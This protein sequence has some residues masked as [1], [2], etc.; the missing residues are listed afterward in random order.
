M[1]AAEADAIDR[2]DS[3]RKYDMYGSRS[4]DEYDTKRGKKHRRGNGRRNKKGRKND[5]SRGRGIADPV[6]ASKKQPGNGKK[7]KRDL[8]ICL[9]P[10]CAKL[11][12]RDFIDYCEHSTPSAKKRFK[13]EWHEAKV[14]NGNRPDG[15]A[16]AA[17][18][19]KVE[20]AVL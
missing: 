12:R 11:S 17:A 6:D 20:L 5:D 13:K 1:L 2:Q 3:A 14:R 8:P 15:I 9:N 19:M 16:R 4:D 10:E 7:R 18:R